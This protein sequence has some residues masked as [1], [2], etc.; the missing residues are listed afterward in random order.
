V[1][2]AKPLARDEA[3]AKLTLTYF[4]GHGPATLNDFVWWSGLTAAAAREGI[5]SVRSNLEETAVNATV[6]W[7]SQA[8]RTNRGLKRSALQPDVH[9]LPAYDEYNV[10]YKS[11]EALAG[12]ALLSPTLIFNGEIVGNWKPTTTK[13]S[14]TITLNTTRRL[15]R[16]EKNAIA[17]AADRYAAYLRVPLR[18]LNSL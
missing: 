6:Y 1:A 7:T 4:R 14:V 2:R 11:R 17:Q 16:A 10:A 8:S 9:L 18:V 13:N 3:L 12:V 5:A 15:E